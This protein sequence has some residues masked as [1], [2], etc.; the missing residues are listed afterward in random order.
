MASQLPAYKQDFLK[1]AIAGGVLK[2]GSF[3]LKS[4]RIS[5]YFFNAGEF[6]SARLAGAISAAFAQTIIDAQL[7]FDI[8]FG[9]A[10]KGIRLCSASLSRL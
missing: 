1:A 10:Y 3:E 2:F 6:Y 8:V 5:P 7:D 4:K 9:P